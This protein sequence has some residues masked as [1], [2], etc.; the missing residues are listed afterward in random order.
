MIICKSDAPSLVFKAETDGKVVVRGTQI[1]DRRIVLV[2][3]RLEAAWFEGKVQV[4]IVPVTKVSHDDVMA[5]LTG[6]GTAGEVVDAIF[7]LFNLEPTP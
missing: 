1:D 2:G 4:A 5:V 6:E 7:K 3:Q